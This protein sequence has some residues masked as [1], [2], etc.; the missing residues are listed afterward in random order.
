M[1]T[2]TRVR[3]YLAG[4][5]AAA[6]LATALALTLTATSSPASAPGPASN[7]NTLV[8]VR[9]T[10]LGR[11]LVDGQGRTL[12]LFTKDTGSGSTCFGGCASVWPPVAVHGMPQ[13][14]AGT[15]AGDIATITRPDGGM[16]LS[17]HGHPVYYYV[18]DRNAGD[19]AGQNLNQ[20]GGE[21]YAL[22][23]AGNAISSAPAPSNSSN[24]P[25]Y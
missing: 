23:P 18:G 1:K 21:W 24:G 20:F 22:D 13:A 6:A 25:T 7:A 15:S 17:Y 19:T 16:Q 11:I 3:F 10:G 14:T 4:G 2:S 5:V 12:Y 9:A 8:A